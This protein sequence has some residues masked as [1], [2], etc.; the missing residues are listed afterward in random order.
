M[1]ISN[2]KFY[3]KEKIF[4]IFLIMFASFHFITMY[5]NDVLLVD[6]LA[7]MYEVFELKKGAG[8]YFTF[9]HM[10][11]DT[12]TMT[13]RP[14][15]GIITGTLVYISKFNSNLYFFGSILFYFSILVIFNT[16]KRIFES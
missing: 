7:K 14:I 15:S 9:I 3:D 4:N 5:Y 13:S 8:N 2:F 11:L 16:L 12:E 1:I 6:D 10:F